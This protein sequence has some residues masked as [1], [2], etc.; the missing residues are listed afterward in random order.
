MRRFKKESGRLDIHLEIY[1]YAAWDRVTE[2]LPAV[3]VVAAFYLI[4]ELVGITCPIKFL[5]GISCAGCGMSRAWLALLHLDIR[6]AFAYHPLFFTPPIFMIVW[7]QKGHIKE[8]V[9]KNFIFTMIVLY[10]SVYFVRLIILKDDIAVFH[11]ENGF[12]FRIISKIL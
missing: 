9:Y 10:V 5:T 6:K 4:M 8:K 3:F 7:M 11:P 1:N 2:I 12:I